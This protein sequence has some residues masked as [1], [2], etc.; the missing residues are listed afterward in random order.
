[1][2]YRDRDTPYGGLATG[3]NACKDSC[4]GGLQTTGEGCEPWLQLSV[5]RT[6][7]YPANQ[8]LQQRT[9]PF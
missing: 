3:L 8:W 1:M 5:Q 6:T 4:A 9:E 7:D 2:Q